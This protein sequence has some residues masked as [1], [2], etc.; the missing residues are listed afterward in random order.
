MVSRSKMNYVN[1]KLM[2]RVYFNKYNVNLSGSRLI[3]NAKLAVN[4]INLLKLDVL[5]IYHYFHL[6]FILT[7]KNAMIN[8]FRSIFKLGKRLYTFSVS[9][10]LTSSNDL[11]P[12]LHKFYNFLYLNVEKDYKSKKF[13]N[14]NLVYINTF[15]LHLLGESGVHN[16]FYYI[17]RPLNLY[18]HFVTSNNYFNLIRDKSLFFNFFKLYVY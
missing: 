2:Q 10:V 1:E 12:F 6:F 16:V 13:G 8:N 5:D 4:F 14:D 11:Y 7:G 9:V 17:K 15:N 18:I 3:S